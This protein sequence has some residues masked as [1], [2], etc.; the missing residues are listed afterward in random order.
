MSFGLGDTD[1]RLEFVT[2]SS[3]ERVLEELSYSTVAT[4]AKHVTVSSKGFNPALY[5]ALSIPVGLWNSYE[6]AISRREVEMGLTARLCD[7]ILPDEEKYERSSLVA[8]ALDSNGKVQ[9]AVEVRLQP[10]DGK[11]PFSFPILDKLERSLAGSDATTTKD[12]DSAY[13]PYEPPVTAPSDQ[14]QPYLCNLFTSEEYRKRGLARTLIRLA[15]HVTKNV[16][17]GYSGLF[18]HVDQSNT[19]AVELYKQEGWTDVGMR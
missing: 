13:G 19:A 6:D 16:W 7:S 8:V 15:V 17:R 2:K 9:A 4:F 1:L 14:V 11:I 10:V 18:L 12:R 5:K 3:P